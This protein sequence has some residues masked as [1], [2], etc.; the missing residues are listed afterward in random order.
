MTFKQAAPPGTS[1]VFVR[2]IRFHSLRFWFLFLLWF[3]AFASYRAFALAPHETETGPASAN[4]PAATT[5]GSAA[6][7]G[8]MPVPRR[9]TIVIPRLDE[10]PKLADFLADPVRSTASHMLR[11]THFVQRYPEDGKPSSEDTV[12]YL[13]Y[14]H[15]AFIAAF[16]CRDSTPPLIRA[17]MLAR[18]AEG[19][20]DDVFVMLDTFHDQRRAFLFQSNVLGIQSDALYSEQTGYDFSFDTVWDTWGKR[21]PT[22]FVVLM[23]IPFASLYFAKTDP[24]EMRTWGIILGRNIPHTNETDYWPRSQSRHRGPAHSGHGRRGFPRRRAQ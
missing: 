11:I 3:V 16:I 2:I 5:G 23:R 20:D 9:E 14:T 18:D 19:S 6:S 8:I 21:T 4:L 12:A 10:M 7:G 17:H 13:G 15:E 24:G 1:R 22:G